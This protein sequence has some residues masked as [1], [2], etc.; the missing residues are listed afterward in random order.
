M[1]PDKVVGLG[2]VSRH[3]NGGRRRP[4]RGEELLWAPW[5]CGR[6]RPMR[7]PYGSWAP[8]P[9]TRGCGRPHPERAAAGKAT[10]PSGLARGEARIA[11]AA[12]KRGGG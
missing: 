3:E 6:R 5:G 12:W 4:R 9:W 11:G 7:T 1:L 2:V 8:D 10:G